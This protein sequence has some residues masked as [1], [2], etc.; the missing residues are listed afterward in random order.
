MDNKKNS[1][2]ENSLAL[3]LI[4]AQALLQKHAEARQGK[5]I[6]VILAGT[7]FSG[8]S[9]AAQKL[10]QTIN[11][12]GLMIH[13]NPVQPS[14]VNAL[15]WQPYVAAIPQQGQISI[16]LSHWY[17]DILVAAINDSQ[18][19]TSKIKQHLANIDA[20]EQD[21]KQNDVE[22]IKFWFDL[23]YDKLKQLDTEANTGWREIQQQYGLNWLKKPEY[24][25]LQQIRQLFTQDWIIIDE[26]KEKKRS[27]SFLTQMLHHLH[28]I[29][30]AQHN[31]S[32]SHWE[33]Q[34]I[35]PQLHVHHTDFTYNED[36]YDVLFERLNR[37]VV[38]LIRKD[39]RKIILVFEG[40]DASGK[41]GI[42]ERI[43]Q[44]SDPIE[45]EI[46]SI[47]APDATAL[48]HPYLWRFWSKVNHKKLTIFDR[49]WY[50]RVLV[51]RV[52]GFASPVA[53]Q[54]AYAE[55][56]RF[57]NNLVD[58][59]HIVIKFWLSISQHE[60]R[61]RFEARAFTPEKQF[62]ITEEDWRNRAKWA[63]Y[64]VAASDMLAY[65]NTLTAPWHVIATDHKKEARIQV[66]KQIIQQ[67]ES[68]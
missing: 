59:N 51:E 10:R 42:I 48:A 12:K 54:R 67:I 56:N 68:S 63:D 23:P 30:Q 18:F 19:T 52:E 26:G 4:E 15:F 33:S 20:F 61:K 47:A 21:L 3:Q 39:A 62:K 16:L 2:H 55:I 14:Q 40:M 5:G 36:E 50:G 22:V 9:F 31:P 29:N 49:S 13:A 25:Q 41:G 24:D 66:L 46:Q 28:Q 64:L 32:A 45:Y 11:P 27:K 60:Q 57:E 6:C 38:D 7:S 35:A 43:V 8:I 44:Y 17:Q 53:W 37:H 58:A 34:P 65:T 1:D